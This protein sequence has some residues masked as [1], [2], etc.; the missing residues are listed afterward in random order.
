MSDDFPF[1][2]G[3]ES[4]EGEESGLFCAPKTKINT[5]IKAPIEQEPYHAQIDED[6]WFHHT[7]KSVRELMLQDKNGATKVKMRADNYYML[8]QYQEA[9]DI[10]KEY[11]QIIAANDLNITQGDG[12]LER[13]DMTGVL[14]ITDSKELQEMALRCAMK[15]GKTEEAATLADSLSAQSQSISVAS[16]KRITAALALISILRATH[17]MRCS[18][19]SHVPYAQARYGREMKVLENLRAVLER[20]CGINSV[21][22]THRDGASSDRAQEDVIA[23][24]TLEEYQQM[25]VLP[26]QEA[27]Q[28]MKKSG[29]NIIED[30]V[31]LE[32]TEFVVNSWDSQLIFTSSSGGAHVEE[33]LDEASVGMTFLHQ[34]KVIRNAGPWRTF[35]SF[36]APVR[37]PAL[38]TRA[39][40]ARQSF[41]T[42]SIRHEYHLSSFQQDPFDDLTQDSDASESASES[43]TAFEESINIIADLQRIKLTA[44]RAPTPLSI[45]QCL[46]LG[47]TVNTRSLL[48]NLTFLNR[49]LPVRF[50]R[51][52]VELLNLPSELRNTEPFM[53]LI[54]NYTLSFQEL[55]T[56]SDH[57]RLWFLSP[58]MHHREEL[59]LD[60]NKA[61]QTA[62]QK[63]YADLL[64][65]ITNRHKQ[66]EHSPSSSSTSAYLSMPSS[67]HSTRIG[68][69]E[70]Q[71]DIE[72]LIVSATQSAQ[73]VFFQHYNNVFPPNVH[74]EHAKEVGGRKVR[75]PVVPALLHHILFE[76][77]K[78]SMRATAEFHG[79]D[80][81]S[82]PDIEVKLSSSA[83]GDL[84][85]QIKD[86]GG[87][88]PP[89]QVAKPFNYMFTTA[90]NTVCID[91]PSIMNA[92]EKKPQR[93]A[94]GENLPLCGFGFGL[95]TSKLY[96]ELFGG[97]LTLKSIAGSGTEAN[98]RLKKLEDQ[99]EQFEDK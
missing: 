84:D 34:L 58:N 67:A 33:Q 86:H 61:L 28:I 53:D 48:K 96:A 51:R 21:L 88:L 92:L 25:V 26:A 52:I 38:L 19:W 59:E 72:A 54:T 85:I 23:Q 69:I 93:S 10:S 66:G 55:Q 56:Y 31:T 41:S 74:I 49:E 29:S 3:D 99:I 77:L 18:T 47:Q 37:I 68:I 8:R 91:F 50:S 24:L 63:E 83:E 76:L 20:K 65:G 43:T 4:D 94:I 40:T 36:A 2:F 6:G 60:D 15:L 81:T 64:Q 42:L 9:Y 82:Y 90:S 17:L 80:K 44:S 22:V 30:S 89:N 97:D 16:A 14:K 45:S 27:L 5:R 79:L 87:G 73:F 11:C 1:V 7:G 13:R 95:A 62:I 57:S 70:P 32:V 71:C 78:N 75:F 12:G 35:Y 46:K 39:K 98:I